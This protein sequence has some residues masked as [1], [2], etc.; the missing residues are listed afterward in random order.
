MST[1]KREPTFGDIA[2]DLSEVW[3]P[4]RRSWVCWN[5][6]YHRHARSCPA[7]WRDAAREAIHHALTNHAPIDQCA[8]CGATNCLA[9]CQPCSV[10]IDEEL[11]QA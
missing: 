10:A 7:Y 2:V 6:N 3:F 5:Y 1:R 9:V 8:R 4:C 11:K